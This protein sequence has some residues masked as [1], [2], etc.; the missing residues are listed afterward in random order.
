MER[1]YMFLEERQ[2]GKACEYADKML[3]IAP[4]RWEAHLIKLLADCRC[5]KKEHLINCK[6]SFEENINY[7]R[8]ILYGDDA[9]KSEL[10][11]YINAIKEREKKK[12]LKNEEKKKNA[13]SLGKKIAAI[14][15]AF[16]IAILGVLYLFGQIIIPANKYTQAENLQKRGEYEAAIDL[17]MDIYYYKDSSERARKIMHRN[18]L[19]IEGM[20]I[21]VPCAK[22]YSAWITNENEVHISRKEK[23]ITIGNFLKWCSSSYFYLVKNYVKE[24]VSY[25]EGYVTEIMDLWCEDGVAKYI[26]QQ[27]E[28]PSTIKGTGYWTVL[29][30]WRSISNLNFNTNPT[31]IVVK[32]RYTG[33][34]F[35]FYLYLY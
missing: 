17:F 23:V 19:T 12:I 18:Y 1:A 2:W 16:I 7:T 14:S 13:I 22:E 25:G 11:S 34:T 28:F 20:N 32:C 10:L 5:I 6:K 29:N 33:K 26:N 3:D 4:R 24:T 21:F 31:E 15:S 9:I 8:V 30:E 27:G 35:N